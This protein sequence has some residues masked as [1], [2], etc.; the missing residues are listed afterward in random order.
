MM[1]R[2]ELDILYV[3]TRVALVFLLPLYISD[4]S[5]Y[6]GYAAKIL[7]DHQVPY[8]DWNFEYPPLALP[9]MLI[10]G[11]ALKFLGE[12][13]SAELFRLFFAFLLLPFD[14]L[15]FRAYRL[16]PPIRGAAFAYVML[17]TALGLLLFD[18]FDIAVGFL[19]AWPFLGPK[20]DDRFWFWW[21][22]GG[23]LKLVP[24]LLAPA[25]Y[26][27]WEGT[28]KDKIIRLVKFGAGATLPL[29][30]SVGAVAAVAHGKLPFFSQHAERGVQ[31]ESLIGSAV[32]FLQ[33]VTSLIKVGVNTNFGAQHLAE[34]GP[35]V[36]LSRLLF[37]GSLAGTFA[38]LWWRRRRWDSLGASWMVISAFVTFGYVLSPQYLLWLVPIALCAAARIPAGPQRAA[39]LGAFS[40]AVILTGIH[41]RFYWDYVNLHYLAVSMVLGRNLLLILLWGLSWAWM[42]RPAVAPSQSA[43]PV[44]S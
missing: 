33:S 6:T 5:I 12:S 17:T 40:W 21:G 41:F 11:L 19:I 29:A 1:R 14:L 23:A 13:N 7:N 3:A 16:A 31:I 37:Y 39:W 26:L 43:A 24:L 18:R 27:D 44:L 22:L 8:R 4:V 25:R 35:L 36:G 30:I 20:R 34:T 2:R 42:E 28:P 10:P 38:A 32:M 9:L 15:L